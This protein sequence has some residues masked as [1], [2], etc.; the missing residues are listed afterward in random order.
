MSEHNGGEGPLGEN[1]HGR[2]YK[3]EENFILRRQSP[4]RYAAVFVF[5]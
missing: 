3:L 1:N 2:F 4:W 5:S